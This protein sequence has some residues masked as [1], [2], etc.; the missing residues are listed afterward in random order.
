VKVS[1][2]VP[3]YNEENNILEVIRRIKSLNLEKEIII[4][5]DG[6]FDSTPKLLKQFQND[7]E[8]VVH[9]SQLNFGKGTA[10]RVG[11]KYAK[12]D[13]VAIQDGD[14]E[15]DVKDYLKIVERF[16]DPNVAVVYGSRFKGKIISAMQWKYW[17]GNMLLRFLANLLYRS[18][19][20]DEATA[21]KAFR[22]D[23]IAGIPLR[24]KRFE[25]CPEVTAKLL[26]R[27]Y[28]IHEVPINYDPRNEA[29]GKKIRAKDGVVAIWTLLKLRFFEK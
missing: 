3:V 16:S 20:T 27:G 29:E 22:R 15:Y 17:F 18:H 7:P 24:C 5:D 10:V 25:F 28:V 14:L 2:I 6:S 4:V 19:I 11:L 1:F 8:V 9:L 23:V 13:I 21:Y 12:G 26:K